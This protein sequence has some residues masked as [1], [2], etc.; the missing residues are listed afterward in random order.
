MIPPRMPAA[1]APF[2][3]AP[4]LDAAGGVPVALLL[5]D[6]PAGEVGEGMVMGGVPALLKLVLALPVV[7]ELPVGSVDSIDSGKLGL[8][9]GRVEV[10]VTTFEG[11]WRVSVVT[12]VYPPVIGGMDDAVPVYVPTKGAQHLHGMAS[13]LRHTFGT[14]LRWPRHCAVTRSGGRGCDSCCFWV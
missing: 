4:P 12:V 7:T 14:E 1:G 5:A 6:V 9:N 11:L 8:L 10:I 13:I 3:V 2:R